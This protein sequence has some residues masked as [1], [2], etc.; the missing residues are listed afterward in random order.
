MLTVYPGATGT[1]MMESSKAGAAE[2]FEYEPP[3]SVADATVEA[4]L[5]GSLTV[6]RGGQ[7]RPDI[8]VTKG[9]DPV[10]VYRTLAERQALL[11]KAVEAHSSL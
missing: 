10:P 6:V 11:E 9:E 1:P 8:I 5:D 3:E 7:Q 4:I 2:G